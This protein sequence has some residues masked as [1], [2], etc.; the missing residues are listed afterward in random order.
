MVT[1][2][3]YSKIYF[4]AADADLCGYACSHKLFVIKLQRFLN[5]EYNIY[6]IA[7]P[8]ITIQRSCRSTIKK[9]DELYVLESD[10]NKKMFY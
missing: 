9:I 10:S 6:A 8:G 4:A 1:T 5:V 2:K 7:C 3:A